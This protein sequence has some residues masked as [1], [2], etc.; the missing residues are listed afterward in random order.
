MEKDVLKACDDTFGKCIFRMRVMRSFGLD[1]D[2]IVKQL[3][4]IPSDIV[5]FAWVASDML[6]KKGV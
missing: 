4:D 3:A 1:R 6:D 5:F 2:E